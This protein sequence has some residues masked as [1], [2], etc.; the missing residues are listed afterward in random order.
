MSAAVSPRVAAATPAAA[1]LSRRR[2]ILVWSMLVVA[3]LLCFVSILTLFVERQMLDNNEWRNASA[4]VIQDPQ[5]R[6]G[7]ATYLVNQL[8]TSVDVAGELEQ[9]LPANLKPLAPQIAASLR[10][11]AESAAAAVLAR[12]RVQQLFINASGVAHEKLVNVLENKTGFGITTGNGVVTLNVKELLQQVTA[13]LG[14]PGKLVNKIPKD[15]EQLVLLKSDQLSTAQKGV[16]ILH[17]L[18]AWLLILV[19]ALY[20]GAVYLARGERRVFLLR[21]GWALV[22]IGLLVVIVRKRLGN[23]AVDQ[24]SSP[25]YKGTVHDAWLIGT[26]I[27]GQIGWA[28][29][30]YGVVLV[31]AAVFAGPMRA[32][33]AGRRAVAPYLNAYP[34]HAAAVALGVYLLILFWGPTHALRMWWGALAFA[35]LG[36][37]AFLALRRQTLAEFPQTAA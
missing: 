28:T 3:S 20:A 17:A 22:V 19:V 7:L 14:L 27:L 8:Y 29:F 15:K 16:Q 31:L 12:P 33:V 2:R 1:R 26:Q 30:A 25:D 36:I 34:W 21:T 13:T 6:G 32:A 23:Y 9:Q 37:A 10:R 11:P 35:L 18:S 5:I 4:K 24:L